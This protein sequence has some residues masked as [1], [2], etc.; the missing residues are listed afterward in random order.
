L[1]SDNILQIYGDINRHQMTEPGKGVDDYPLLNFTKDG[2]Y[3]WTMLSE[4]KFDWK[5]RR[6]GALN[7]FRLVG[8]L[9]YSKTWWK[10]N[11]SEVEAPESKSLLTGSVGIVVEM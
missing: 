8:S 3:D 7:Y 11:A 5:I 6:S 4:F 1:A 10:S 2:I 9:G